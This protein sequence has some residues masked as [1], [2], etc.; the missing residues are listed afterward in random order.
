MA[1]LLTRKEMEIEIRNA[2]RKILNE[3]YLNAVTLK[4]HKL[5]NNEIG[6]LEGLNDSEKVL[7]LDLIMCILYKSTIKE[8]KD[9]EIMAYIADKITDG[10]FDGVNLNNVIKNALEDYDSPVA[11]D[12]WKVE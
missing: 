4:V 5:V 2:M 7:L 12:Y 3:D 1:K 8:V 9:V 10:V 11:R 6:I